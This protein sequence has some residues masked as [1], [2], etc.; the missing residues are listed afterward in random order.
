MACIDF[1]ELYNLEQ[2]LTMLAADLDGV[3]PDRAADL[4]KAMLDRALRRLPDDVRRYLPTADWLPFEGCP[5]CEDEE[6]EDH[7]VATTGGTA[8]RSTRPKS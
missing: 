6:H 7:R 3:S 5:L 2:S 4:A 1:D 8:R